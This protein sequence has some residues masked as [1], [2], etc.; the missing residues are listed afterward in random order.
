M[1][2]KKKPEASELPADEQQ[3][4]EIEAE[5]GKSLQQHFIDSEYRA[6]PEHL[7]A[8]MVDFPAEAIERSFGGQT[9]RG[10]DTT[11]YGYQ[12]VADRLSR[13]F[14]IGNWR[15]LHSQEVQ[16]GSW[17]NP[18]RKNF[19]AVCDM[20]LE[21]GHW[22]EN[23]DGQVYFRTTAQAPG[24]GS[25]TS[26]DEGDARKGGLT[27]ALKK[28]AA[29]LTGA[30]SPAYRKEIDPDNAPEA[31]AR[32]GARQQQNGDSVRFMES[33]YGGTCT[34]CQQPILK[35]EQM[36]YKKKSGNMERAMT[37]HAACYRSRKADPEQVSQEPTPPESDSAGGFDPNEY[38]V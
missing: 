5:L 21:L 2:E 9:G 32:E 27:N 17:G 3:L 20:T 22:T 29:W 1:D 16:V 7:K 8:C 33:K 25:H 10:Y 12:Y 14:G 35:G 31:E 13:V 36:A 38:D 23:A 30:G 6:Q 37:E 24:Y 19:T 28:T 11:G 15:V 18:P 4:L 34:H 26:A